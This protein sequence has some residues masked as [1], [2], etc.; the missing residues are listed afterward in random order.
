[1]LAAEADCS[2]YPVTGADITSRFVGESERL[3]AR[4][5]DRARDNAPSIVFI[6]EIDAIGSTRGELGAYDRQL[7]Q[8]LQEIDGMSGQGGIF[9]IA[10]TNRPDRIDPAL[11]RG[12]R[13]SRTLEIPLPDLTARREMLRLVT[14]PMPLSGVDLDQLAAETSG[15]SGADLKA[16]CQQ[17]ALEAMVRRGGDRGPVAVTADDVAA[18]LADEVAERAAAGAHGRRAR[19]PLRAEG[20]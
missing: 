16:L 1:V 10:A 18:A 3:I 6:D 5:F 11:L 13:L 14:A 12:G 9:V 20:H 17:A 7:D 4:L 2:F 8:L 15:F 19:R